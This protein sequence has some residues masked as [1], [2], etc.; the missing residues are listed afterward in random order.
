MLT[1]RDT[2]YVKGM[3][4][5]GDKPK[6]IAMY[7][8]EN[9]S[10]IMEVIDSKSPYANAIPLQKKAL[11]RPGPYM[12]VKAISELE[13]ILVEA[14]SLISE[15]GDECEESKIA[16]AALDAALVKLKK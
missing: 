5:R 13:E 2:Q 16:I 1:Y 9:T 3:L 11:P 15:A 6:D 12:Y 8:N 14:K 10:R 4:D 7:F